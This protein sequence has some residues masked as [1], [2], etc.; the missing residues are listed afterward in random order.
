MKRDFIADMGGH[1]LARGPRGRSGLIATVGVVFA[2]A[3]CASFG[4]TAYASGPGPSPTPHDLTLTPGA[5]M[6]GATI[7]ATGSRY[8][9]GDQIIIGY[10]TT[11]NCSA[12]TPI[13]GATATADGGGNVSVSVVIP[14]GITPGDYT[15]CG[16]DQTTHENTPFQ[17]PLTVLQAP[18][19]TVTQPIV[20]GQPVT[21]TGAN[22][23]DP[24]AKFGGTIDI[25]YGTGTG[26]TGCTTAIQSG[27]ASS[28]GSFTATFNAPM[29]TTSTPITIVAVEPT[30]TCGKSDS[31]GPTLQGTFTGTITVPVAPTLSITSPVDSGKAVSVTGKGFKSGDP[32]EVLYG[33]QGS[34]G[35]AN[36]VATATADANGNFS[37]HFNAPVETSDT[38]LTVAAVQP[39]GACAQSPAIKLQKDMLVKGQQQTIPIQYCLIGLLLLLLLL[40]LLFLLFRGRRKEE[41]VTIEERDTVVTPDRTGGQAG[42]Q[43][44]VDRQ[45]V[46]RDAR[47][48]EYVI[49]EEVTTVQEDEEQVSHSTQ[50][51]RGY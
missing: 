6:S 34:N 16:N 38:H 22:F 4:G 29:V 51:A 44:L 45:I 40:L 17:A 37:T 21:V 10:T 9:N 46:A 7:T 43:A 19:L 48:K 12:A 11:G 35:C 28:S 20:A 1:Q 14:S 31:G 32:I 23:L 2:F 33:A 13:P 27:V 36:S 15:L 24:T 26:S 42:G 47:G 8:G 41:P 39:K 18:T 50:G 5:G 49:A 30:G 3:L 25:L